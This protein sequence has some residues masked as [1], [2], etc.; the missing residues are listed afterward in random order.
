MHV[1]MITLLQL[2]KPV[3][4]NLGIVAEDRAG[5]LVALD[6]TETLPLVKS[7]H[8]ATAIACH[9]DR[10]C[11]A[12]A[13]ATSLEA[14][15]GSSAAAPATTVGTPSAVGAIATVRATATV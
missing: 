7:R 2:A 6:E 14:P 10:R 11:R 1:H 9:A 5:V 4:I 13:V 8:H 15:L 3:H 12:S